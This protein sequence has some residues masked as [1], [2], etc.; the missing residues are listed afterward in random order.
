MQTE[1]MRDSVCRWVGV[2]VCV[3]KEDKVEGKRNEENEDEYREKGKYRR[4]KGKERWRIVNKSGRRELRESENEKR[5]MREEQRP[6]SS[7]PVG[8]M[9]FTVEDVNDD[10]RRVDVVWYARVV[11]RV[12][13]LGSFDD[14]RTGGSVAD[15]FDA[16]RSLVVDHALVLVPENEIGRHAALPQV[17]RQLQRA[18]T[19]D[20]LLGTTVDLGM[21]LCFHFKAQANSNGDE[22]MM[23]R[24]RNNSHKWAK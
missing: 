24:L 23:R 3:R 10:G 4:G 22:E 8:R 1:C 11:A 18:P 19:L 9:R 15:D 20:V 16:G 7:C 14:E 5:N 17:A 2:F 6:P 13:A 12:D 21:S